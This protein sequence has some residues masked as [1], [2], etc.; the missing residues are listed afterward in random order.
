MEN[1]L[2]YVKKTFYEKVP[3]K[4]AYNPMNVYYDAVEFYQMTGSNTHFSDIV[5]S[6]DTSYI[7]F[8]STD[9]I[10]ESYIQMFAHKENVTGKYIVLKYRLPESNEKKISVVEF[11]TS[12]TNTSING[13]DSL[14][15]SNSI[16]ADGEWHVLI[17]D[18]E[19]CSKGA[20]ERG[21]R[22]KDVPQPPRQR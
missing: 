5:L 15:L 14:Y 11:F 9:R 12:T 8:F 13:A 20:S 22:G 1:N 3:E 2:E 16:I 6:S 4:V 18:L 10:S 17:V 19:A 7:S 21:V